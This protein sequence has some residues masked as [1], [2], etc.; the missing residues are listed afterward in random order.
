MSAFD[1]L[2][3][4]EMDLLKTEVLDGKNVFDD[5]T[6]Q[7]ALA[8]G[9][10][11]LTKRRNGEAITW[12]AFKQQ[13]RITDIKDFAIEMEAAELDPTNAHT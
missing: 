5:D 10:M 12:D 1:E 4:A 3:L 6:D 8:G 7:F 2:T 11:W 9:V 13:T